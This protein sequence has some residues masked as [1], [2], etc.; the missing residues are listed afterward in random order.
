MLAGKQRPT[1]VQLRVEL[2]LLRLADSIR[3][4][5]SSRRSSRG[6]QTQAQV[7]GMHLSVVK[8]WG[9]RAVR[10]A[11]EKEAGGHVV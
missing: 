5:P 1:G 2:G 6:V 10:E 11:D 8:P 9:Q 7:S 4:S 3:P